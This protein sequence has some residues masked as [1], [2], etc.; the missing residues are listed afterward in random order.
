MFIDL[1]RSCQYCGCN[2]FLPQVVQPRS[3]ICHEVPFP[4]ARQRNHCEVRTYDRC[5]NN[6][7]SNPFDYIAN[8]A[9]SFDAP[10]SIA[11]INVSRS[12]FLPVKK[13]SDLLL[14]M[15]N[16]YELTRGTM[17]MSSLRQFPTTPLVKLGEQNFSKV[18]P[19]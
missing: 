12:R 6:L 5:H 10:F 3:E 1:H 2:K 18:K 19:C 7:P 9:P 14:V 8:Q 15:S 4:S 17:R 16:L 13:T 11:G